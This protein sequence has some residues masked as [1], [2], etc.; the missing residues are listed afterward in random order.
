MVVSGRGESNTGHVSSAEQTTYGPY[1]VGVGDPA[2][3]SEKSPV[4]HMMKKYHLPEKNTA[5]CEQ[6][7]PNDKE[8][9]VASDYKVFYSCKHDVIYLISS[10]RLQQ[11]QFVLR[12]IQALATPYR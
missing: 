3:T 8:V 4:M 1:L 9:Q 7:A 6:A 12:H 10:H 5:D 2:A 11:Q